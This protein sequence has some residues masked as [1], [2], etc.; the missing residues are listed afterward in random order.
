M[1]ELGKSIVLWF[2]GVM[3]IGFGK[4]FGIFLISML[5]II[6]LR[7]SIPVAYALN[8]NLI[9]AFIISVIGN[10]LPVPIILLFV[11]EVFKFMK[12]HHI[13]EKFILKLE[14]SALGKSEKVKKYEFWGLVLFVAIPLPGTGAW[15]GSLIASLLEMP[16]KKAFLAVLVGV[17]I[18]AVIMSSLT[19][20]L[21]GSI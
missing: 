21:I 14:K 1:K 2:T 16:K 13:L 4:L 20:G 10:M 19:Y 9:P 18:A 6:E 7:G 5:P 3:G 8:V 11:T 15:T 17:L 12:K